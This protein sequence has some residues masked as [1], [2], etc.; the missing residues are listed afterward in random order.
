[1]GTRS[2]GGP[3]TNT[4]STPRRGKCGSIT[5]FLHADARNRVGLAVF[6]ALTDLKALAALLLGVPLAG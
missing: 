3:T 2:R 4:V 6:G 1:M 5:A